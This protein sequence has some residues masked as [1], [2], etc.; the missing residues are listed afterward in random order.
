MICSMISHTFYI[1]R[2]YIPHYLIFFVP[3]HFAKDMI[4]PENFENTIGF[5]TIRHE[6]AQRCLSPMGCKCCEEMAFETHFQLIRDRLQQV[7]EFQSIIASGR[8]FP[9]SYYFDLRQELKQAQAP[10]TFMPVTAMFN[11][12]R[13]LSTVGAIARFFR[14]GDDGAIPYP[15][16]AGLAAGLSPLDGL[17][18]DIDNVVDRTG[19]VKD[20]ASP[21]LHELRRAIAS[22]M[23]SVSGIMQ[24]VIARGKADG[25]LDKDTAPSMR[26]GRLVVPVAPMHKRKLRGIVHDESAT[27]KTLFIEPEEIVETNNRIREAQGEEKR[28]IARILTELTD[29]IRP[30]IDEI[31][32]NIAIL[33]ELDFARA[34]ALFANDVGGTLPNLHDEPS[35]E[36]YHAVH[37]TLLLAL[38]AQGKE[39]V[40][41]DIMLNDTQRIVLI[42]G[43]NAGGKSICL[44][45]VGVV[46]YM[47]Q[48]GIL[49]TVYENSHMGVFRDIMVD[50]GDQQS[51]EDDLSTYSSHLRNMKTFL[52]RGTRNSLVLIDEMGSGTE[53]QIGGAIAQAILEQLN[54]RH[55]FG[56]VTTHYH[57]LKNFAQDTEGIVNGAMLYDRQAMTPLFQ[58]S[59]GYPGSS[60]AIEIAR[61]MGLPEKVIASASEIAG[62]D[63]INLDRYLLDIVRDRKYWERKRHEIRLKEKKIEQT[64]ESYNTR[65]EQL[66]L[67]HRAII[68]GAKTEA[69]EIL[70]Q[71]NARIEQTIKEIKETQAEKEKTREIRRQL[72]EFKERL[73]QQSDNEDI[74]EFKPIRQRTPQPAK[75]P[76]MAKKP[77]KATL[78]IGA[79]VVLKGSTTVG[80]I[81]SI[82]EKYAVVAFGNIKTRVETTRIEPTLRQPTTTQKPAISRA[83]ADE[84]RERQLRFK[85]EI[86]LRGCRADEALQ[87]VTYFI[88]DAIQFDYHR[89]R[90]LHG[91]GTG[92]LREAIR[93]YLNTVDAV[94]SYHDEHVQLGGAGVTIVNLE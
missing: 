25:I 40:P 85:T 90:I 86:D 17:A 26:D 6:I 10:G 66:N 62:S 89:L 77:A 3:L 31:L 59:I 14:V 47:T 69:K 72:D 18:H 55:V 8:E 64:I 13:S 44:K 48:C 88:D 49:P 38:R 58:L 39:V 29:Q 63:Y 57:N 33:G 12:R 42:S 67:E 91:T 61:K 93:Q 54:D 19:E 74:A 60:F 51:I 71:S 11:L 16:L 22:A 37:P 27:G 32:D 28:E 80:T 87:A 21:L 35:V 73:N 15:S 9:L 20:T 24:R 92:A 50:I 7:S 41:L 82:D 45:T 84:I 68:K 75:K 76:K 5:T 34:K 83:T 52:Q 70:A 53:P 36:W 2:Y 78:E 65:L 94:K 43:P 56:V 46:Q 4:Y 81:I 30:H 79:N 1:F 23:A